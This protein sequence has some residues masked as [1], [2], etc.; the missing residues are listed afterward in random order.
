MKPTLTKLE[1]NLYHIENGKII[2]GVH[3]GITGNVTGISGNVTGISGDVTG[4]T[5]DVTGITGDVDEAEL[6]NHERS[7]GLDINQLIKPV[8]KSITLELT[9]EQ[10]EKVKRYLTTL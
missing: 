9:E 2:Q 7:N 3:S 4:I 1:F 6:T 10:I 8:N 5:G